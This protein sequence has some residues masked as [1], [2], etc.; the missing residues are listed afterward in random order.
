MTY[1]DNFDYNGTPI[2]ALT[3]TSEPSEISSSQNPILIVAESNDTISNSVIYSSTTY[4]FFGQNA[5]LVA[6]NSI[7]ITTPDTE[8]TYFFS[9]TPT[10]NDIP[11][12]GT[13]ISQLCANMAYFLESQADINYAYEVTYSSTTVQIRARAQGSRYNISSVLTGGASINIA[14]VVAQPL[15][16]MEAIIPSTLFCKLVIGSTTIATLSKNYNVNNVYRFD[17]S[18]LL[19]P[20]AERLTNSVLFNYDIIQW[21]DIVSYGATLGIDYT[22]TTFGIKRRYI[23][24][25]IV[26]IYWSGKRNTRLNNQT[27]EQYLNGSLLTNQPAY[28]STFIGATELISFIGWN[29]SS[30]SVATNVV[31]EGYYNDGTTFTFNIVRNTSSFRRQVRSFVFK[32]ESIINTAGGNVKSFTIKLPT[33]SGFFSSATFQVVDAPAFYSEFIFENLLGGYDVARLENISENGLERS[34]ATYDSIIE[35][36]QVIQEK[37]LDIQYNSKQ[38]YLSGW[39]NKTEYEWLKEML[40]SKYVKVY[41]NNVL[42]DIIIKS[43]EW[44]FD[45]KDM[46]YRL[47]IETNYTIKE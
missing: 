9:A 27:N 12:L 19:D 29:N 21:Q 42:Y 7:T 18:E 36:T 8:L 10:D 25:E 3:V 43:Y 28:K 20:Y 22:D 17:L 16:L 38:S 41:Q 45:N 40:V 32:T 30:V 26:A 1:N 34:F 15:N 46:K 24:G 5:E 14:N 35:S 31:V 44:A 4:T 6:G 23:E 33:R 47:K 2:R 13:G 37:V 39:V 11:V